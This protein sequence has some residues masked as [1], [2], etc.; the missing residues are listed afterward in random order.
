MWLPGYDLPDGATLCLENAAYAGCAPLVPAS[1]AAADSAMLG[2]LLI[3]AAG[4]YVAAFTGLPEGVYT[5]TI[6]PVG[7]FPGY[8]GSVTIDRTVPPVIAIVVPEL[9]EPPGAL[10]DPPAAP[11]TPGAPPA[12]PVAGVPGGSAPDPVPGD[13]AAPDVPGDVVG[14]GTG[15]AQSPD[16]SGGAEPPDGTRRTLA[17]ERS[18]GVTSLP[19]TGTGGTGAPGLVPLGT[20]LS[21]ALL[22]LAGVWKGANRVRH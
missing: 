5:L 16:S 10:P 15:G 11:G 18:P 9:P 17:G 7:S 2:P 1:L 21:L 13:P 4:T 14:D 22:A 8:R 6:P 3:Q 20:L 12:S 19:A